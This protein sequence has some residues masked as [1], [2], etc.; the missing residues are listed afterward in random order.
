MDM[1]SPD[2]PDKAEHVW[3]TMRAFVESNAHNGN[4]RER[5][6]LGLGVGRLKALLLLKE[7]PLS[8]GQIAAA[9]GVDAAYST[10][11]VDKL[12]SLGLVQRTLD[13]DDRRRKLVAL[14]AAGRA[15]V[16]MAE[17]ALSAAPPAFNTLSDAELDQL[18]A[19][20]ARLT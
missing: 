6:G 12:E 2:S 1:R 7:S 19:L 5:L 11:I 16:V 17:E 15:A 14:T 10:I 18:D 8:L 20:L 9:H 3:A 13:P 4:V